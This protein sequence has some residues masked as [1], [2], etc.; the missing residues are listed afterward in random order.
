[1]ATECE[2]V[3]TQYIYSST[4]ADTILDIGQ[5]E[6]QSAKTRGSSSRL[7]SPFGRA[8]I[9]LVDAAFP[10]LLLLALL[11]WCCN[12]TGQ[13]CLFTDVVILALKSTLKYY[14]DIFVLF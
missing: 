9:H 10:P 12:Y 6:Q 4:Y 14:Y 13:L 11:S 2:T 8:I 3:G 7:F 5:T 1:M